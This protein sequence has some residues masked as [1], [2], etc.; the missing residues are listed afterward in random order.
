MITAHAIKAK[1]VRRD[2][3]RH[4]V[5]FIAEKKNRYDFALP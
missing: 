2:P 3:I 1:Q 5:T 4:V